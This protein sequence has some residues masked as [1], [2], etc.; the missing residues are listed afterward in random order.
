MPISLPARQGSHATTGIHMKRRSDFA[1]TGTR[2][3]AI[4]PLLLF[5][6]ANPLA[7]ASSVGAEPGARS[8][9]PVEVTWRLLGEL[10]YRTGSA[11]DELAALDGQ[12]VKVPGFA[13]PL[14]DWSST[15]SEFLLVPYYG[16]CVHTP[17]PPANQ[18]VYIEMEGDKRAEL[19]GWNPIW[20]EGI[21]HI[22]ST[23]SYY[24][25]VGFRLEGQRVYPY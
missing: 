23:M 21:L 11:S 19:D 20:V 17:P 10:D 4:L 18:L 2:T 7:F 12:L 8:A 15:A 1:R 3:L 5:V 25:E 9:I 22:E 14:E 13:V 24:G 6:Q 16:A